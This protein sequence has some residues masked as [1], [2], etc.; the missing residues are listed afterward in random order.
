MESETTQQVA[1]G[2]LPA[3]VIKTKIGRV[4]GDKMMKTIVVA[5]ES[6]RRHPIYNKRVR[7]TRDFKVHD[8]TNDAHVGDLVRIVESR[9]YSRQK[10]WRLDVVLERR[11]KIKVE[12]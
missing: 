2:A 12:A 6:Q 4:V 10:R 9:P 5:I 3:K 8:E 11:E 1:A 7:R